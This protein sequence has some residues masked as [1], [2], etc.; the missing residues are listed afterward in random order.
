M[1]KIDQRASKGE[2]A[3]PSPPSAVAPRVPPDRRPLAAFRLGYLSRCLRA[4]QI[5]FW[6]YGG[7]ECW[8]SNYVPVTLQ[9]LGE[10]RINIA[11]EIDPNVFQE[12][13]LVLAAIIEEHSEIQ[14]AWATSKV[15]QSERLG[16]P[17]TPGLRSWR[18][19]CSLADL[20]LAEGG[21][22]QR[23]S[24]FGAALGEYQL[25]VR[26]DGPYSP[27]PDIRPVV[28]CAQPLDP[29]HVR[30]SPQLEAILRCAPSLVE[31]GD[32]GFLREVLGPPEGFRRQVPPGALRPNYSRN[33][34]IG[35][36]RLLPNQSPALGELARK[37]KTGGFLLPLR[38]E[39]IRHRQ[40][41]EPLPDERYIWMQDA[42]M[43]LAEAVQGQ[44][45]KA[46]SQ[47]AEAPERK[48]ETSSEGQNERPGPAGAGEGK[49]DKKTYLDLVFD[50]GAHR[51]V[52]KGAAAEFG[53]NVVLWE[54]ARALFK[55]GEGYY[56]LND[57]RNDVWE[58][59]G[60]TPSPE[61]ATVYAAVNDVR[62][63]LKPL[64]VGV[65]HTKGVGYSLIALEG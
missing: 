32:V 19:L 24:A 37:L 15:Y 49:P 33:T 2:P 7:P 62:K 1:A 26:E 22:H 28:A 30:L 47:A 55:R 25:Q 35:E 31:L 43:W 39:N 36:P 12:L 13:R 58:R 4:G 18:D 14:K 8:S 40:P 64:G 23:L 48:G 60:L 3:A 9:R 52:R 54:L 63:L 17:L 29:E 5:H 57:L 45:R 53:G 44:L 38:S 6:K 16:S 21:A 59:Y 50:D 56:R 46:A 41:R 34:F 20:A 11:N 65:K 10:A 61:D 51:V 42:L 27:P